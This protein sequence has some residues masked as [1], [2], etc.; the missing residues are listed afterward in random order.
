MALVILVDIPEHLFSII[1]RAFLKAIVKILDE[2][3]F[4]SIKQAFL[5]VIFSGKLRQDETRIFTESGVL[6]DFF[7]INICFLHESRIKVIFMLLNK[8]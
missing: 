3:L 2:N 4:S 6:E 8:T 5:G 1:Y 7:G